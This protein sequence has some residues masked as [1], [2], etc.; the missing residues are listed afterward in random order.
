MYQ[1]NPSYPHSFCDSAKLVA[2]GAINIITICTLRPID[3]IY[4][5]SKPKFCKEKSLPYIDWGFGLTPS[6]REKT[7]PIMAFGWDRV[8]QLIYIN[9]EGTSLEIDGFY[10]SEKEIVSLYFLGDSI[11]FALFESK[12]GREAK[13]LYTTK[14]YP[15]TYR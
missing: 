8:I 7:V 10:Y 12:D 11:L 5:V 1:P 6:H 13:I 4:T 9:D 14:F 3:C 15:G 2:F